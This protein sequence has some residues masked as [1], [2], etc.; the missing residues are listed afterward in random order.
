MRYG[1][2]QIL[3]FGMFVI[4][5]KMT[6]EEQ[7]T[8]TLTLEQAL[9]KAAAVSPELEALRLEIDNMSRLRLSSF[10]EYLPYVQ[11]GMRMDDG[12]VVHSPDSRTRELYLSLKQPLTAGGSRKQ[13]RDLLKYQEGALLLEYAGTERNTSAAVLSLF[14]TLLV[15]EE[16][17]ASARH[18]L[19]LIQEQCAFG[20]SEFSLGHITR[21]EF[22]ASEEEQK[23]SRLQVQ[24]LEIEQEKLSFN[25]KTLTG[26]DPDA[27]LVLKGTLDRSYQGISFSGSPGPYVRYALE[28]NPSLCGLSLE[29]D[30]LEREL[31]LA[32]IPV[33]PEIGLEARFS[34]SGGSFPLFDP[35]MDISLSFSFRNDYF[36]VSFGTGF[37]TD[38]AHRR[39][40]SIALEG[41][42]F[43]SSSNRYRKEELNRQHRR[44]LAKEQV[45][46]REIEHAV[47]IWMMSYGQMKK[48]TDLRREALELA[49]ESAAI[50]ER[51]FALGEIDRLTYLRFLS[52]L[53]E[54]ENTLL[55]DI[56]A[57]KQME[58]G[59][60]KLMGLPFGTLE[61]FTYALENRPR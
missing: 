60:E 51:E 61:H 55:D 26:I 14:F 15:L 20:R 34:A 47:R 45:M 5:V 42:V 52:G 24:D 36:P 4:L 48:K 19:T 6:G 28:K 59:F 50:S 8:V 7:G 23:Q 38:G 18:S 3:L 25:L 49:R 58:T 30:A 29:R 9:Q 13:R 16:K 39:F 33:M 53:S 1:R 57:L 27:P 56:L 17:L 46:T 31:S 2:M 41:S 10:R 40:R 11:V 12:I 21:L 44:L 32:G 43:P 35:G 37:G 54:L 22:L